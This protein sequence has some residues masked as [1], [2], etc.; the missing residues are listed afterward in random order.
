MVVRNFL[1]YIS[2]SSNAD[3]I[4]VIKMLLISGIGI[5]Q[6]DENR[7]LEYFRGLQNEDK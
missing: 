2:K 4:A 7:L 1:N 3:K 5:S 6:E